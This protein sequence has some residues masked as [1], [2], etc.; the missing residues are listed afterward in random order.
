MK[1]NCSNG[2]DTC[3]FFLKFEESNFYRQENKFEGEEEAL[4]VEKTEKLAELIDPKDEFSGFIPKT[5]G[6]GYAFIDPVD[7][8][9][10]LKLEEGL[11]DIHHFSVKDLINSLIA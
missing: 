1:I 8:R 5:S 4:L 6:D 9:W 10:T 11:I 3:S 2:L 7:G